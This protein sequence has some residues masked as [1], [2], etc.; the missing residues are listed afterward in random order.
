MV[1]IDGLAEYLDAIAL[2]EGVQERVNVVADVFRLL[3]P[4]PLLQLFVTDRVDAADKR[5]WFSLWG[6][7]DHYWLEAK[8]F[9]HRI[10]VD[11]SGFKSSIKYLGLQYEAID[12]YPAAAETEPHITED[13]RIY[14]EVQ[15]GEDLESELQATGINAGYLLQ[16]L[17][18]RLLP[19]LRPEVI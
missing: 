14:I 19:N 5:E 9:Q 4:E 15:T 17:Q 12:I 13:S 11:I 16:I 6:F 3:S 2:S 1:D 18:T 7:T 10:D 8:G